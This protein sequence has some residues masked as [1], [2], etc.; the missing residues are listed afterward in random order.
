MR[1]A[2]RWLTSI[3][4]IA[5]VVQVGLAGYGAFNAIHKADHVSVSKKTIEHGFDAHAALGTLIVVVMLL[6]L[7]AA[8]AAKA[9][10]LAVRLAGVLLAL[11]VLQAILGAVSTSAP[12]VGF[13]HTVNALAIYAISGL[14]AHRAWTAERRARAVVV[15]TPAA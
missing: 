8:V 3:L 5:I 12:A 6:L 4:F 13:L 11:G 14:L 2:F 15:P 9:G 10:P 7:I 1:A